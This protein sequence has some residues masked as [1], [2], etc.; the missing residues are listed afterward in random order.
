MNCDWQPG[1]VPG[2]PVGCGAPAPGERRLLPPV[3]ERR[4][5][6]GGCENDPGNPH[7][8]PLASMH[9]LLYQMLH[10]HTVCHAPGTGRLYVDGEN[11][12]LHPCVSCT[13]RVRL[14]CDPLSLDE[15]LGASDG[16]V[17]HVLCH[18]APCPP[19]PCATPIRDDPLD[20]C[21]RC[22][23]Q[24][25]AE[26]PRLGGPAIASA[27]NVSCLEG[28][29]WRADECR[30]CKCSE[31]R[32]K[33]YD[34]PCPPLHQCANRPVTIKGRCCPICTGS[35]SPSAVLLDRPPMTVR[36]LQTPWS[37]RTCAPIT[38]ASTG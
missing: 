26:A 29:E 34:Q 5:G 7:L 36:P 12:D 1:G 23:V 22:P 13:C 8:S 35:S 33:C 25:E 20:C 17:G 2:V 10:S 18:P 19:A 11:W 14:F 30:S 6:R 21:L 24:E 3:R 32:S 27:A 38:E 9:K 4:Q 31:G 37:R 28:A 15:S 16:Q